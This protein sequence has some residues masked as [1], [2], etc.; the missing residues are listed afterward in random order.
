MA[1]ID[2]A[3]YFINIQDQQTGSNI[4]D[5]S[6]QFFIYWKLCNLYGLNTRDM[7]AENVFNGFT[8]LLDYGERSLC[9]DFYVRNEIGVESD[10]EVE[11]DK[12]NI[13]V[14]ASNVRVHNLNEVAFNDDEF[15]VDDDVFTDDVDEQ[16]KNFDWY[17]EDSQNAIN[18]NSIEADLVEP[19][20]DNTL[21]YLYDEGLDI[22]S[23]YIPQFISEQM[24][25]IHENNE[26]MT[27]DAYM[28]FMFG[29]LKAQLARRNAPKVDPETGE[30]LG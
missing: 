18:W 7:N 10:I 29:E 17:V 21:R 5:V 9:K 30:L 16:V 19:T 20:E 14:E 11:F 15:E 12:Y 6:R 28:S 24:K 2:R 4:K 3:M 25:V 26:G 23:E 27:E 13:Q 8:Q 22:S 1:N